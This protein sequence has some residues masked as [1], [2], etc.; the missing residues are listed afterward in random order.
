MK[1]IFVFIVIL[2]IGVAGFD[3]ISRHGGWQGWLKPAS[4]QNLQ[5]AESQASSTLDQIKKQIFTSGPLRAIT[6][7]PQS[8]LTRVGTISQTNL[9]RQQNNLPALTESSKLDQAALNK[10]NDMFKNQYFE[11]ISP[12]GKGPGDLADDVG[13]SYVAVGENLA[14]GNFKD[15]AALVNAWMN[16]PGHRANIL[17][18]KYQEIGVAVLKGTFEGK[19][20]WLAVQEFGKPQSSCPSVDQNLKAQLTVYKNDINTLKPQLDTLKSY[21]DTTSPKTQSETDEY[22]QK[23][24]E[25]NA[26]VKSYNNKVDWLK[27]MTAQYN[28]QVNVYN[29]C[30]GN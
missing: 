26:L 18:T 8:Y 14:L 7:S 10:V 24:A 13:Y 12:S 16:S 21:L 6:G 15:D 1:K 9:Q 25:Y 4:Y 20:V 19:T 3:Y 28:V 27:A 23:V 30:V 11:H 29:A 5:S 17:N 22:N 2:L